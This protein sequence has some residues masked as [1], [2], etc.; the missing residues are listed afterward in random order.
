MVGYD[1]EMLG[2]NPDAYTSPASE[3]VYIHGLYLE[4][5]GWDP[6][7]RVLCESA[8]K[9][10]YVPAPVMWFRPKPVDKFADFPHYLCP[11]YRT[12][13]RRGVLAT[14]GHS[15]NFVMYVKLPSDQ[16]A[17]HWVMRGL[18]LLSQLSD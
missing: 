5:A 6:V 15:T 8:P 17:K 3:G 18:A 11:V 2:T 1:F 12:A 4:G 10:L 16:P 14:T 9:V 7:L 13:D